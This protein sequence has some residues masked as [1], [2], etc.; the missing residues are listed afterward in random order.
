[1]IGAIP[2]RH[3]NLLKHADEK[4]PPASSDCVKTFN[5]PGIFIHVW[6]DGM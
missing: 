4:G 1:V 5:E 6:P 2:S 3:K